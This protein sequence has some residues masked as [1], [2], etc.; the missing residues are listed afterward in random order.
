MPEGLL[1][2][3][4][5]NFYGMTNVGGAYHKGCLR[6]GCGTVYKVSVTGALTTL[7][8]FDSANGDEPY[9]QL[10]QGADG[11]FYG[12]TAYGGSST[13][14]EC[15]GEFTYDVGCGVIFKVTSTG[16]LTTLHVFCLQLGCADGHDPNASL[17]QA[18]NGLFYGTTT[19]GSGSSP[20]C[21]QGCGVLFQISA[22]GAYKVLHKFNASDGVN[23]DAA[24]T[25]G[26]DGQLYGATSSGGAYGHGTIFKIST[27]GAFTKLHDFSS[28]DG[29]FTQGFSQATDGNFYGTAADGGANGFGTIFQFSSGGAFSVLY[30]FTDSNQNPSAPMV[31]HTN[32][33]FYGATFQ[34]GI[35]NCAGGLS[36]GTVYSFSMGLGPFVAF[37]MKAGRVGVTAEI[38]GQGFTGAT[39]VAF[40]GIP[41]SYKVRSDT[42]LTAKVPSGATTGY[43][44]VDTP[45]GALT[46][47][48]AF[49]VI[50]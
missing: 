40:N 16:T 3:T 18:N 28:S 41:A 12:T 22:S 4:D 5:G 32:G 9:D 20:Q 47:N 23:P 35:S 24:L 37:V 46:S 44:T 45:N 38:L 26:T 10:V 8:Q 42:F 14:K 17:L 36:C 2:A 25:Q 43:V 31:Q 19:I 30:N 7:V 34:G 48:V 13:A 21:P 50:Q 33:T 11:N 15:K 6:A 49:E 27:A 39:N 29:E 1:K